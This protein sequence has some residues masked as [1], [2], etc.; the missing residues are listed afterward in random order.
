MSENSLENLKKANPENN[1]NNSEVAR[2]AQEKS[3]EKRKE[4][5]L[6]KE[7]LM[8]ILESGDVQNKISL[9]LVDRALNGDVRAFEVIRDTIGEK[10]KDVVENIA[11][12]I[13]NIEGIK[14]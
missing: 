6:L 13:I 3:V 8:A 5:K 9:A 11:P 7:E 12:P 2:K 4:R 10:P 1:F 14:I